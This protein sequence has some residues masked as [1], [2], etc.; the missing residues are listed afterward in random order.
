[1]T[2]P[3][4][5]G[6]VALVTLLLVLVT[7]ASIV[8]TWLIAKGQEKLQ[9]RI[10]AETRERHAEQRL[11][12]QRTQLL[13]IW[14]YLTDMDEI[15]TRSPQTDVIKTVNTLEL[16][17]V[18]S[19]AEIIDKAI[20]LRIFRDKFIKLFE[21]V[22]DYGQL[23]GYDRVVSGKI[24]LAESPAATQLYLRLIEERNNRDKP[25]PLKGPS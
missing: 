18:C 10:S 1:M 23:Q 20:V 24:L 13:P 5:D 17:A 7:A 6:L 21:A 8:A 19:E 11:Y 22:S 4:G 2:L 3:T 12:Q 14:T 25:A 15:D 9:D 16:V